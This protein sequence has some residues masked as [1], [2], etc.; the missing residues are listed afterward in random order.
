MGIKEVESGL[1][2]FQFYHQFDIQ[3]ILKQG[4]WSF[5][6]H[7]LILS[8]LPEGVVP[9]E[10]LLYT[11]PFWG[12]VHDLPIGFMSET[13]GKGLGDFIGEFLEYDTNNSSNFWRQYMRIRVLIV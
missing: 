9:Q 2:L 11:V 6:K 5:D 8:V 13:V 1:F 3:R 4:P 12:Q 10:V 7:L